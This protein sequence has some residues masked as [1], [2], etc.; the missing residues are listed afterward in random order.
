MDILTAPPVTL[1]AGDAVAWA[2][3]LPA[4]PAD[5][6]WQLHYR[7]L[8]PSGDPATFDAAAQGADHAVA[9][10]SADTAGWQAGRATLV[11]WV[12]RD[13]T[14]VTLGQQAINILP[15]LTAATS[16][17]AR[18]ANQRALDDARAALQNYLSSGRG[19]V[20]EYDV[21]GRRMKFRSVD[22]LRALIQFYEGQ[23]AIEHA[24]AAALAGGSPGRIL[25][26]F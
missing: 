12:V 24:R 21:A 11:W 8:W 3:A 26:R 16:H 7:V 20:L 17:D 10:A 23:V 4:Y 18:S 19:H 9:L 13:T 2:V 1:R 22:E 25:T 5:D 14:R 15:D 6:G